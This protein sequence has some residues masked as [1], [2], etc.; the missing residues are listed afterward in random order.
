MKQKL[1]Y[2][3]FL[4][5]AFLCFGLA[6]IEIYK[7]SGVVM[8]FTHIDFSYFVYFLAL[9]SVLV[10]K[11]RKYKKIFVVI[12]SIAILFCLGISVAETVMFPNFMFSRFHID[13]GGTG[14]LAFISLIVLSPYYLSGE[15]ILEKIAL[16]ILGFWVVSNLFG[17]LAFAS[18]KIAFQLRHLNATYDEKMRIEWGR[19]YDCMLVVK[20]NT[21][22]DATIFIPPQA[23]VWQMEG[24]EFLVR[25]FLYPRRIMHFEKISEAASSPNPYFIYSWGYWPGDRKMG[26]WPYEK[27]EAFS[28]KFVDETDNFDVSK[29]ISFDRNNMKNR[30]TCGVI[31]P[32]FK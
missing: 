3:A 7:Y 24:N 15:K 2:S 26:A 12:A 8:K 18:S 32:V 21:P 27:F 10:K 16:I 31:N 30:K 5:Y 6:L 4:L 17:T 28:G 19:F 25:Y 11:P 23:D 13:P 22:V 14:N 1:I 9:L 20:N 29:P